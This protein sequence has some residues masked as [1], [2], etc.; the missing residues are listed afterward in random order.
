MRANQVS[1]SLERFLDKEEL[2]VKDLHI[3]VYADANNVYEA[4]AAAYFETLQQLQN[5]GGIELPK[6]GR[7]E[8]YPSRSF[9]YNNSFS[10]FLKKRDLEDDW[11]DFRESRLAIQDRFLKK[12][13]LVAEFEAYQNEKMKK[14]LERKKN[15]NESVN[16]K[17]E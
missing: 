16:D 5:E 13:D 11:R 2:G 12:M 4:L 1:I 17:D 10:E 9:V 6:F 8:H 3:S 7:R 15:N 14:F